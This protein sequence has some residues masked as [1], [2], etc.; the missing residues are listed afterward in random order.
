M[1]KRR[2]APPPSPA[3]R[4]LGS[5]LAD[6]QLSGVALAGALGV[7]PQLVYA[8]T[9]GRTRPSREHARA[10]DRLTSGAVPEAEWTDD[11]TAAELLE[12]ACAYLK[13]ASEKKRQE[14]CDDPLPS[15]DS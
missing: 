3:S 5:W 6:G 1:P 13:H 9:G 2:P 14:K 7:H 4:L 8:W 10:I 11:P 15:D 12:H